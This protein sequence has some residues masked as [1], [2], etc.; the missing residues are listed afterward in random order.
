MPFVRGKCLT[1]PRTSRTGSSGLDAA[2][3][4]LLPEV[5]RAAAAARDVLKWRD[6]LETDGFLCI[7]AARVERAAGRDVRQVR[8]DAPDRVQFLALEVHPGDRGQQPLGVRA[9][10]YTH[11]R[12]HETDSYLVCRLLLEKKKTHDTPKSD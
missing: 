8:R 1:S 11:L 5:A 7:G 4:G 12:A 2:I 10:S 3:E 6:L 9:V